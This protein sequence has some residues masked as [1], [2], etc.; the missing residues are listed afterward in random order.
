[1]SVLTLSFAVT[2]LGPDFVLFLLPP[3]EEIFLAAKAE[4]TFLCLC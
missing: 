3:T 4:G 1:M 2:S